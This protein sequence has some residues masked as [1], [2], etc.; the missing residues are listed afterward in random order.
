[1]PTIE[2]RGKTIDRVACAILTVSDTRTPDNDTSG[3]LIRNRLESGGHRVVSYEII[4]D[5]PGQ[6]RDRVMTLCED[7]GIQVVLVTGGTGLAKRDTTYEVLDAL[8]EKRLDGFGELFRMLS[9]G[10]VSAAAMLSRA[11]AGV[12]QATAVFSMPG[13]TGAVTLAMDKLILPEIG[14]IAALLNE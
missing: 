6:I 11:T 3:A 10:E 9:Y 12:S 7:P 2:H 4:P 1:M 5:E 8:F 14:H 13:S